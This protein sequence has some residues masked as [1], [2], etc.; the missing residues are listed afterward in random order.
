MRACARAPMRGRLS[1]NVAP[2]DEK[3][4]PASLQLETAQLSQNFL[5]LQGY[6]LLE[7]H[8][9]ETRILP[10]FRRNVLPPSSGLKSKAIK[11]RALPKYESQR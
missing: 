5:T 9:V 1:R 2:G 3:F 6:H 7:C 4:R 10:T 8:G 11:E